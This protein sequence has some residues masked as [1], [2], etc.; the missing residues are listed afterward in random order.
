M[1]RRMVKAEKL[2]LGPGTLLLDIVGDSR[3]YSLV[4]ADF[5]RACPDWQKGDVVVFERDDRSN[6]SFRNLR[7]GAASDWPAAERFVFLEDKA[8]G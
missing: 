3:A 8:D 7:T 1:S 4:G 2:T 5:R 6:P